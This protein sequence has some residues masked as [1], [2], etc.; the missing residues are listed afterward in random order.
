MY[1][2]FLVHAFLV[3]GLNKQK[4]NH[5]TKIRRGAQEE[6]KCVRSSDKEFNLEWIL[7][8]QS[9]HNLPFSNFSHVHAAYANFLW[10]VEEDEDEAD[11]EY[12]HRAVPLYLHEGIM[13]SAS[14]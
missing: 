8:H 3:F 7:R 13:T 1:T 11:A 6:R 14:A 10:E 12:I 5:G 4:K 9:W 2:L